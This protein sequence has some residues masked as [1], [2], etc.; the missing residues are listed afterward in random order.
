M[1]NHD[2]LFLQKSY[3]MTFSNTRYWGSEGIGLSYYMWL[4]IVLRIF[5]FSEFLQILL[6]TNNILCTFF[7]FY[8]IHVPF[9][10]PDL[11]YTIEEIIRIIMMIDANIYVT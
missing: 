2:L 5:S 1:L 3:L 10:L 8:S 7:V 4:I 9:I 11:E 6:C